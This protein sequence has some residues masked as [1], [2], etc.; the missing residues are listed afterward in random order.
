MSRNKPCGEG[1]QDTGSD[2]VSEALGWSLSIFSW[3]I[4]TGMGLGGPEEIPVVTAG[5]VAAHY[6]DDR[7]SLVRWWLLLPICIAGVVVS[8]GLLYLIGRHWGVRLLRWR[9]TA[10]ILP[11]ERL[12]R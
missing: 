3:L 2:R 10:R 1:R 6:S 12:L 4:L 9:W 7:D 8:D 5:G 11:R